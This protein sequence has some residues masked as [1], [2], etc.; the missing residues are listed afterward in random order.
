VPGACSDN[1]F[2][3]IFPSQIRM[4]RNNVRGSFGT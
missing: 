2:F 3:P 1:N 4:A